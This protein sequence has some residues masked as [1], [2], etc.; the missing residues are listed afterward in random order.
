MNKTMRIKSELFV[1]II[2]YIRGEKRQ[3]TISMETEKKPQDRSIPSTHPLH[4]L[5]DFSYCQL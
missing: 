1:T 2:K 5:G 3:K 4:I